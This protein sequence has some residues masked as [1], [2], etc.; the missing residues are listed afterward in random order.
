MHT[1]IYP[2]FMSLNRGGE[3]VYAEETDKSQAELAD[4]SLDQAEARF[5]PSTPGFGRQQCCPI[6]ISSIF[7][8]NVYTVYISVSSK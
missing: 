5:E 2:N 4:L 3:S 8:A 1:P 6:I 7:N